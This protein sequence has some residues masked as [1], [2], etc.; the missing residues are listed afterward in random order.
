MSELKM[1][2]KTNL[3][4]L[5]KRGWTKPSFLLVEKEVSPMKI[6]STYTKKCIDSIKV[7]IS[8]NRSNDST[9]KKEGFVH[10]LLRRVNKIGLSIGGK[11]YLN[12]INILLS[13]NRIIFCGDSSPSLQIKKRV[14]KECEQNCSLADSQVG[15]RTTIQIY[16]VQ[17]CRP[18]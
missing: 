3:F 18:F 13:I 14:L 15:S 17:I 12:K 2:T 7:I 4:T 1:S 5:F 11:N 10:R 9:N 6:N 16:W 8:T